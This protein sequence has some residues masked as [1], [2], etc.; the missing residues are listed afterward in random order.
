MRCKLRI[1]GFLTFF[2]LFIIEFLNF[3][4]FLKIHSTIHCGPFRM[5]NKDSA[6]FGLLVSFF[7][8]KEIGGKD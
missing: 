5:V 6:R 2:S 8:A 4:E 1:W 7:A 3:I